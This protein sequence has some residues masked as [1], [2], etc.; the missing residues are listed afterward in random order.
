[1]HAP[2]YDTPST[3]GL[4]RVWSCVED[5]GG[6]PPASRRSLIVAFVAHVAL[7]DRSLRAAG[8]PPSRRQDQEL[9]TAR[10]RLNPDV[11]DPEIWFDAWQFC[12]GVCA[13]QRA[14]LLQGRVRMN[15]QRPS[16][17]LVGSRRKLPLRA[18]WVARLS[19]I[20]PLPVH[21]LSGRLMSER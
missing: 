13:L 18:H 20:G 3:E 19:C 1:M 9:E 21:S 8:G 12:P 15:V 7:V 4:S 16:P 5:R 6:S 17:T 11:S 2:R 10:R 14:L